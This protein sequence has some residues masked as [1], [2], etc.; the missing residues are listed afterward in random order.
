MRKEFD[1]FDSEKNWFS[2]SSIGLKL[3]IPIFS[4]FSKQARVEKSEIALE[5]QKENMKNLEQSINVN[6]SN[7]YIQFKN[8][9]ENIQNEKSNLELAQSVFENTQ[10]EFNQGKTSSLEL[11][12]SESSL[13]ETQNNYYNKLLE[14]YLAQ[15]DLEKQKGTLNNFINNIK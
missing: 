10:I 6:I 3:N 11:T 13:R 7:Y 5:I 8:A 1:F 9:M 12:Q 15:L 2:N 4:G 14:L